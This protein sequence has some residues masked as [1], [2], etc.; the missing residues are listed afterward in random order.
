MKAVEL[1]GNSAEA[2][3]YVLYSRFS[4]NPIGQAA[5]A[6]LFEPSHSTLTTRSLIISL[7]KCLRSWDGLT[8][9][10]RKKRTLNWTPSPRKFRLILSSRSHGKINTT[11]RRSRRIGVWISI[12]LFLFSFCIWVDRYRNRKSQRRSPR[13]AESEYDG[14]SFLGG[15]LGSGMLMG[16]Q[17]TAPGQ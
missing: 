16:Y 2:H 15:R 12:G 8:K 10:W 13:T 5:R 6:N 17:V 14:I 1:D 11:W 7:G 4:T 3:A 9:R